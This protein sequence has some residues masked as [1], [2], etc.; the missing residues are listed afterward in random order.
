MNGKQETDEKCILIF[1]AKLK[2]KQIQRDNS[3]EMK[4]DTTDVESVWFESED[5]DIQHIGETLEWT[6]E[7]SFAIQKCIADEYRADVGKITEKVGIPDDHMNVIHFRI[8]K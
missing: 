1:N 5:S 7:F 4:K 3:D 8:S 6:V 2:K